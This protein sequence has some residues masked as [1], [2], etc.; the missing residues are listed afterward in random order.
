[1]KTSIIWTAR[2]LSCTAV[3]PNRI[4][5]FTTNLL[6]CRVAE[7]SESC[8]DA[9]YQCA[10]TAILKQGVCREIRIRVLCLKTSATPI[11]I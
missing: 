5:E 1:M 4:K 8:F 10:I 3:L 7:Q 6:V 2:G 9:G 11:K